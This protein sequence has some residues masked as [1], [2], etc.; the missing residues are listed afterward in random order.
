MYLTP[1]TPIQNHKIFFY[2]G[3]TCASPQTI[4]SKEKFR[5]LNKGE[6]CALPKKHKFKNIEVCF[7]KDEA[8][9]SPQTTSLRKNSDS[10]LQMRHVPHS[11]N[12]NL[13]T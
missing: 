7:H 6:A 8:C 13:K 10:L 4:S 1:L 2:K 11:K 9:A 5:F 3:E 12:T